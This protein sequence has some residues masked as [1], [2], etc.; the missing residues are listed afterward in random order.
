[1][2]R[3]LF[4]TQRMP[5]PPV[6]GEK[7]RCYHLLQH[8]RRSFDVYLGCLVDDPHD[9]PF[10]PE[11][12]AMCADSHFA[13]IDRRVAKIAC[14]RGLLTGEALSVTFYRDAGLARWV[15]HVLEDVRPEAIV[16]C[17]SNMAPYVLGLRGRERVCLVDLTDVDSEKWRAY[18]ADAGFPMSWVY[19]REWRKVARLEGRIAREAD[20]ST[21]VSDEEAALFA[22]L[23]PAHAARI[24]GISN[25][26][27][28]A[29]FDPALPFDAPFATDRPTYVFTGTMDY[30]P[31]VGAVAWFARDILPLIRVRAPEACFQIV[32]SNPAPEVL[33]LA[34]L[35]GVAVV[36][37]VPDVRPYLAY[38][39][40]AVAPMR[41]ARGIQNKVLEAMAM[42]RPTVV[43]AAALEGIAV[44]PGQ[45][46]MLADT[47]EAI[48]EACLAAAEPAAT[49]MG[50]A[51]RRRVLREFVWPE[52]LRGFDP[53]LGIG[54]PAAAD[55]ALAV[56]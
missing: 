7:I 18:A 3:L 31:N 55:A 37:R 40:A 19:R 22:R 38:A 33:A 41:I 27:D 2:P 45:E 44:T 28:G 17:S 48:A 25:G 29:Y 32:G 52:R 34:A 50:A 13:Q 11:V 51:A 43:T 8:L 36:G 10:I 35:P 24:V 23:Q 20:W 6:K 49:A 46:V 39:T 15:R 47:P 5:F 53:L 4:L 1:M 56:P 54:A 21:F 9:V 12:A 16:V 26:V 30:P 42:A 14:L